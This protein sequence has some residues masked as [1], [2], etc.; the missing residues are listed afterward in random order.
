ML[1]HVMYTCVHSNTDIDIHLY[2]IYSIATSVHAGA[3]FKHAHEQLV[4]TFCSG[5]WLDIYW[6]DRRCVLVFHPMYIYIAT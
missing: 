1:L 5:A 6:K 2:I 3:Y 4:Q